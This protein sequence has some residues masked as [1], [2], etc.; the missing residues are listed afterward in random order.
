MRFFRPSFWQ[1]FSQVRTVSCKTEETS[2][3]GSACVQTS[4]K[5]LGANGSQHYRGLQHL[6]QI[7]HWCLGMLLT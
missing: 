1:V 4:R 5:Q 6:G 2:E 7:F 3:A